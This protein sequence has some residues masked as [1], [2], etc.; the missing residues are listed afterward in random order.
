MFVILAIGMFT[1]D[2]RNSLRNG[3]NRNLT[4]KTE[5]PVTSLVDF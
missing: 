2:I 1:L 4:V 3:S 5:F